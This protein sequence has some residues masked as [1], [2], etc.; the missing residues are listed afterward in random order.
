M[1]KEAALVLCGCAW[2]IVLSIYF[3]FEYPNKNKATEDLEK[4]TA[5]LKQLENTIKRV[6]TTEHIERSG[7][8][9]TTATID[10]DG[11]NF[12][13]LKPGIPTNTIVENGAYYTLA[14][15]FEPDEVPI[16]YAKIPDAT[17]ETFPILKWSPATKQEPTCETNVEFTPAN[18]E[19]CSNFLENASPSAAEIVHVCSKCPLTNSGTAGDEVVETFAHKYASDTICSTLLY[20]SLILIVVKQF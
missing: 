16:N 10:K 7:T 13:L 2:A 6:P 19:S 3:I 18:S 12:S 8:Y 14:T 17:P 15:N 4:L 20:L 5:N 9:C 11:V 1:L